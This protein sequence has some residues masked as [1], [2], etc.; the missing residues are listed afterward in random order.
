MPPSKLLKQARAHADKT[1]KK[2]LDTP[3]VKAVRK[4][5]KET[6]AQKRKRFMA[7]G[8]CGACGKRKR[9]KKPAS[10]GGGLYAECL[11]CKRYYDGKSAE[12]RKAAK[13]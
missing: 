8:I 7:Q 4:V 13:R 5:K 2:I 6:H 11:T 3:K 1:I 12:Y 10:K 9:A